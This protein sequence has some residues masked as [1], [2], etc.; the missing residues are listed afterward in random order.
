M[1]YRLPCVPPSTSAYPAPAAE[2]VASDCSARSWAIQ[3]QPRPA[4][5]TASGLISISPIILQ[6]RAEVSKPA[7]HVCRGCNVAAAPSLQE[8][9]CSQIIG[10][11][12]NDPQAAPTH[13]T[14]TFGHFRSG[15]DRRTG[16]RLACAATSARPSRLRPRTTGRRGYPEAAPAF[17]LDF[18]DTA[19]AACGSLLPKRQ[20]LGPSRYSG[21][22]HD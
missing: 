13:R 2:A 16:H 18:A 11:P 1:T 15:R 10:P 4:G 19:G 14:C 5:N 17:S 21:L 8:V 7:D 22:R 20:P 3:R 6:I 12:G 9:R